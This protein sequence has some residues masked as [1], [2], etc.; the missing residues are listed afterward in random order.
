MSSARAER[1]RPARRILVLE[2]GSDGHQLEWLLHLID[3]AAA[4]GD[5]WET[6]WLVVS[7]VLA[8]A[9]RQAL[10]AALHGR[11]EIVALT[12]G[13]TR[14]CAHPKL[15]VSGFSRWWV[16]RRYL[17]R[18]GAE[19]GHFLALDHLTL[20]LALGFGAGGPFMGGIL[21]RPSVH[22]R[23]IGPYGPSRRE[24]LRDWRKGVLY[25]L[26]L[27]NSALRSV[28]TLDPHFADYAAH[29]YPAGHKVGALDDPAHPLV[30]GGPG[31]CSL[32]SLPPPDRVLFSLFG[33]LDERK[34][35]LTLLDALARLPAA[36][37]RRIAVVLA[38]RID[39]A[40]RAAAGARR[41]L[42]SRTRPDLWLHIEDRRLSAAEL[43]ALARRSDVI[44]APYQRFVG[45][46]GVMLW[47]AQAGKPLLTQDVGLV[48]RL[49]RDH[50][51]GLAL[52][53]S[54]PDALAAGIEEMAERGAER[55][56]DAAAARRFVERRTPAAFA[57]RIFASLG[58]AGTRD[59]AATR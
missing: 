11:I 51:L 37:T 48:G 35:V 17:R 31:E 34:G 21:F 56:F 27:R 5:G 15:A 36:T 10:P 39:P 50:G 25:R 41:E 29:R 54:D 8:D 46:S 26:M 7:P 23:E 47:A 16:M 1:L 43:S 2:P 4:H 30:D 9:L 42:L 18:C 14:L 53:V 13:E 55:F 32:A 52:D 3:H 24:R 58:V 38:G 45:S 20:P 22:Y 19:A 33:Y 57:E 44:L 12:P 28:L 49:V 6:L 40:I 59:R